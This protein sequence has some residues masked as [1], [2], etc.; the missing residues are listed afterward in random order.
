MAHPSVSVASSIDVIIAAW[1]SSATIERALLSALAE[2]QVQ[3]VIVI[4]DCSA[5]DTANRAERVEEKCEGR[6]IVKRL[7]R[8]VGPAAARNMG[9]DLAT[10]PWIAIL[11]ADDFY[12]P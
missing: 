12:L 3:T 2:P 4:D 10:A 7:P 6:T 1:N 8:N 9:I 5:D 11:D